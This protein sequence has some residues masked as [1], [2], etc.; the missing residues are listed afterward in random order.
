MSPCRQVIWIFPS[1]HIH[2]TFIKS[3]LTN[4]YRSCIIF[5]IQKFLYPY[6]RRVLCIQ[7]G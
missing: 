1:L 3:P 4:S 2:Q 5:L 6:Y 7:N